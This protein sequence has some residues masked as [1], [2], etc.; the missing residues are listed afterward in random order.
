[1]SSNKVRVTELSCSRRKCYRKICGKPGQKCA[2]PNTFP[3]LSA[4]SLIISLTHLPHDPLLNCKPTT[5]RGHFFQVELQ[6]FLSSLHLD[7]E[8]KRHLSQILPEDSS[9]QLLFEKVLQG[10]LKLFWSPPP[11]YLYE[12]DTAAAQ[13]QVYMAE[14]QVL[15]FKQQ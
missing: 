1:M 14:A 10:S 3:N 15:W 12:D 4:I 13:A 9:L 6:L 5:G 2:V 8:K 7:H 11:R